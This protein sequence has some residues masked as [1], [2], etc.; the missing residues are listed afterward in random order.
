MSNSSAENETTRILPVLVR[1]LPVNHRQRR[2]QPLDV[3]DNGIAAAAEQGREIGLRGCVHG[4]AEGGDA[5]PARLLNLRRM[6]VLST[7]STV[8]AVGL[9]VAIAT[10]LLTTE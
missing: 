2:G 5:E 8:S 3:A 9:S 6:G 1:N 4:D 10:V 7:V